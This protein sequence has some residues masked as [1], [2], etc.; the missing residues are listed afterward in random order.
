VPQA[1]LCDSGDGL[2]YAIEV[3]MEG[4]PVHNFYCPG[5]FCSFALTLMDAWRA[6]QLEAEGAEPGTE[7]EA[8][9]VLAGRPRARRGRSRRVAVDDADRAVVG[10]PEAEG[11]TGGGGS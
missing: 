3:G 8:R 4:N 10:D 7:A 5:C 1:I 11:A 6:A 9:E 2:P